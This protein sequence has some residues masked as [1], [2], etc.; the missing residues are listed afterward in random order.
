MVINCSEP[1]KHRDQEKFYR[2]FA[3]RGLKREALSSCYAM[4][5]TTFAVTQTPPGR[6]PTI[7]AVGAGGFSGGIARP[8]ADPTVGKICM[9]SGRLLPGCQIRIV[10]DGENDLEEGGVGEIWIKSPSMFDGYRNHPEKTAAA[11]R[12][13]WYLSGDL[14][15]CHEGEY[16][17]IGRKKDVVIVAGNNIYP[18][19]VEV[20]MNDLPGVI[21][22]RVVAFGEDDPELGSERLCVIAE[23]PLTVEAQRR[24]LRRAIVVAGMGIDVSIAKVYLVPPRFLVKSSAGKLSRSA[25]KDRALRLKEEGVSMQAGG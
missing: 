17:V 13:G 11:L 23:T 9:S 16:F 19:D 22:G 5:E 20:V 24:Q 12:D 10:D 18:E 8:A 14:G 4:A 6:E 21:P 7:L 15:F 3:S 2:R 25:N 1:V